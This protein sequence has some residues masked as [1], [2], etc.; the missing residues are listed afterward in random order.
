MRVYTRYTLYT[1]PKGPLSCVRHTSEMF[2]IFRNSLHNTTKEPQISGT[3][4][5]T[6]PRSHKLNIS[7]TPSTTQQRSP[8][9]NI[10]GTPSTTQPSSHKFSGTHSTTQPRSHK[11]NISGT[12][13]TTHP[14]SHKLNICLVCKYRKGGY[15]IKH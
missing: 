9:L 6:Q 3:P 4:S 11:L 13:S 5:T 8:K 7:G 12:P 15:E 10:F 2:Y 14:R 1:E